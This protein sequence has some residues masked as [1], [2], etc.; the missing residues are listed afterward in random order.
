[1]LKLKSLE[2]S[3]NL[4]QSP[5]AGYSNRAYRHLVIEHN[6]QLTTTEMISV[7]GMW[8][9]N[10]A[11]LSMIEPADNEKNISVQLFGKNP[12]SYK[13]AL[14]VL[15]K[16]NFVSII[17]INAGCPAKKVVKTQSGV[18]MMSDIPNTIDVIHAI[19][20]EIGNIPLSIKFR[21]GVDHN[22]ENYLE[23]ADAVLS[24]GVDAISLHSR[25]ASDLYTGTADRSAFKTLRDKFPSAVIFAS[26]DVF[27]PKDIDEYKILGADGV[28]IARGGIGN[29]FLFEGI[30]PTKEEKEEAYKRHL[31]LMEYYCGKERAEKE[32]RKFYSHYMKTR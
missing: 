26:G 31:E 27:T 14:N 29:P 5:L 28:L 13:R 20:S 15:L 1:M 24:A 25:F 10:R 2:I 3:N 18:A 17:D 19:K 9:E 12:D 32:M 6:C 22:N 7:E 23:F 30:M 8:R 11:T 4:I 16:E 21:L